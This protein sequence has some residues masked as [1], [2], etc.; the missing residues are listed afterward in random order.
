MKECKNS[1]KIHFG[2]MCIR[3]SNFVSFFGY[4]DHMCVRRAFESRNLKNRKR[5]TFVIKWEKC[6]KSPI[7]SILDIHESILL[8]LLHWSN[9]WTIGVQGRLLIHTI[10]K[11]KKNSFWNFEIKWWNEGILKSECI[12]FLYKITCLQI[13]E[14]LRSM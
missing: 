4:L 12:A 9:I 1:H 6:Q 2:F 14:S 3:F 11:P 10:C 13:F 7:K 8:I 5:F